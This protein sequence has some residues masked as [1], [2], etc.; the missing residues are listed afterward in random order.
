M[1]HTPI[2]D[3]IT[4]LFMKN[5]NARNRVLEMLDERDKNQLSFLNKKLRRC[6]QLDKANGSEL[7]SFDSIV[8]K[9]IKKAEKRPDGNFV[10][11]SLFDLDPIIVEKYKWVLLNPT[12]DHNLMLRK[13]LAGVIPDK[14]LK[15]YS[16]FIYHCADIKRF[17]ALHR[18]LVDD[19]LEFFF[20]V[21]QRKRDAGELQEESHD[22][23]L[24][25]MQELSLDKF[26][27]I[28]NGI[29]LRHRLLTEKM[30][31]IDK[32]IEEKKEM[33]AATVI[34]K[35]ARSKLMTFVMCEGGNFSIGIFDQEKEVT[36]K[37]DHKY[38][39]RKKQG[40]RQLTKDKGKSI[41]SVGSQIR[42]ANEVKHQENIE[43]ILEGTEKWITESDYVF[44]HA[45]GE[46]TNI[47]FEEGKIL[48]DFKKNQNFKSLC[49]TAKKANFSEIKSIRDQIL[50]VYIINEETNIV[51]L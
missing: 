15:D 37:S 29:M 33:S 32:G 44:I 51:Q 16:W 8:R 48:F 4:R 43:D 49:Y 35:A 36:H 28:E 40:K 11:G 17:I 24:E 38:V 13:D 3:S 14:L 23:Y 46:N 30:K 21:N 22:K 39:I 10:K 5:K 2:G 34:A 25:A 31:Q 12:E 26:E 6:V 1:Q 41:S 9:F 42:R 19:T 20:K 7:N 50:K 47:L 45:P 18:S 27:G